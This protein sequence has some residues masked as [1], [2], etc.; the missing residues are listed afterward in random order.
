[1]DNILQLACSHCFLSL[2]AE[3]VSKKNTIIHCFSR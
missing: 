1:M 2:K 3:L